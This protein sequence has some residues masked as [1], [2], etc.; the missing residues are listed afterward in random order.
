M[1]ISSTLGAA[2]GHL[3]SAIS[4]NKFTGVDT[5]DPHFGNV[6]RRAFG[7]KFTVLGYDFRLTTHVFGL[8]IAWGDYSQR[9][10]FVHQAPHL[11]LSPVFHKELCGRTANRVTVMA[12]LPDASSVEMLFSL[13]SGYLRVDGARSKACLTSCDPPPKPPPQ[14]T[15][16]RES[17]TVAHHCTDV[18]RRPPPSVATARAKGH[19]RRLRPGM[20]IRPGYVT[21]PRQLLPGIHASRWCSSRRTWAT[22]P[23]VR[24]NVRATQLVVSPRA[25]S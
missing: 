14:Q 20:I 18:A 12:Q 9:Q 17:K 24:P 21:S 6:L 8:L 22:R 23:G 7:L 19:R 25:S 4:P 3:P 2:I 11:P 13:L 5:A 10:V 1:K 16:R 15:Y